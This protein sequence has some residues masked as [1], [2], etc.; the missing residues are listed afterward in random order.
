MDQPHVSVV[1]SLT[2][3]AERL[4]E[5]L[6]RRIA[7]PQRV[8]RPPHRGVPEVHREAKVVDE[9]LGPVA[10]DRRL[11]RLTRLEQVDELETKGIEQAPHRR[12]RAP[13]RRR[14]ARCR[15]AGPRCRPGPV[16]VARCDTIAEASAASS[17]K[18]SAASMASTHARA[19]ASS[20]PPY[21]RALPCAARSRAWTDACSPSSERDRRIDERDPDRSP[22]LAGQPAREECVLVAE[23]GPHQHRTG[24]D[25]AAV[26]RPRERPHR[27]VERAGSAQRLTEEHRPPGGDIGAGVGVEHQRL[28]QQG[29]GPLR[30]VADETFG[31][32]LE[33][34]GRL[35]A[36]ALT[37]PAARRRPRRRR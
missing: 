32:A 9:R 5:R 15:S 22:L 24:H 16:C 33:P 13:P 35:D 19:P 34:V 28:L 31:R 12:R 21:A 18:R 8:H 25:V 10:H 14:R 37:V 1:P 30:L 17:P 2:L 6:G 20:C 36:E 11:A 7:P 4:D 29:G 27:R 23:R 3:D 26:R